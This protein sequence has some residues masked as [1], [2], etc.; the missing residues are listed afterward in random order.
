LD[1]AADK[2]PNYGAA[3]KIPNY[4]AATKYSDLPIPFQF[5]GLRVV[6]FQF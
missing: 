6:Q 5:I 4:G 3:D 1:G 2:I